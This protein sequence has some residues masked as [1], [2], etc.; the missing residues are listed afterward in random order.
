MGNAPAPFYV[1][2]VT[3][4][5]GLTRT[6]GTDNDASRDY[7]ES[8]GYEDP[9]N[10][11]GGG[12][13][14]VLYREPDLR[15]TNLVVPTTAPHAGD[16]IPVTWTVTN[17]GSRDT[18]EGYWVDSVYLSQSPSLDDTAVSLGVVPHT[19]GLPMG[20]SYTAGLN[21]T[22]PYGIQ[23]NYYILVYTDSVKPST[24][25]LD[26][27]YVT[28]AM[29]MVPE[30]QGEGDNVTAG[31]LPVQATLLPDLQVT[32]AAAAGPDPMQTDHVYSGQSFTVTYTVTNEG[33][34]ATLA[35][36]TSWT[37]AVYL[38]R[39]PILDPA[40]TYLG[41]FQHS[42][43]LA[44][45]AGYTN[46]LTFQTP[47]GLLGPWYVIV[48]TDPLVGAD[49]RGS[50][51]ESNETNNATATT[52]PLIID[53]PP[54]ADLEVETVPVP[55]SAMAGQSAHIQWTVENIG[56]YAAYGSWSDALYLSPDAT[57]SI[58]DPLLGTIRY[59][60]GTLM[61]GQT[62]TGATDVT[63]PAVAPGS[64]G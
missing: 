31:L 63:M 60:G 7:F 28:E 52:V 14:P 47:T 35:R 1:Y 13:I 25:P 16:T 15:V 40:D 26:V 4:P 22:L 49:P 59:S 18:R 17:V 51:Y 21:V 42:G 46:T 43:A 48:I 30:F 6:G 32:A 37:D 64:T 61:P 55:G 20:G 41:F 24:T 57:W 2:V 39:D 23:G 29:N 5:Y 3:D 34:G 10:N 38:S 19:S 56:T 27:P 58:S 54:P 50:V 53:Q 8:N 44:A 12:S 11:I 33:A 36:Q 9:T 45:G 62:Y